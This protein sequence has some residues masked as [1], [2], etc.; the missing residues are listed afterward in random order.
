MNKARGLIAHSNLDA[1]VHVRMHEELQ[2]LD[3]LRNVAELDGA[4]YTVVPDAAPMELFDEIR[5]A[6]IDITD[7]TRARGVEPFNFGPNTSM[8]YRLLAKH[9]VFAKAVLTPKLTALMTYLLGEGYI[10]QVAT[11]SV[12]N[13]DSRSGHLHADNQF[14]PEPFPVQVHVA[15][16]IWCC[17]DF[18]GKNGSTLV[19]PGSTPPSAIRGRMRAATGRSR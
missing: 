2:E 11:G 7:E 17:D 10:A 16:A 13:P 3:L 1:D 18:N 6:I 8:I 14:F 4:G 15:T 19:V 5:Q 12:L 9:E